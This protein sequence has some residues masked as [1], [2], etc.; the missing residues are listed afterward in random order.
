LYKIL[1]NEIYT[2][3]KISKHL[4]FEFKV[5]KGYRKGDT[6]VPSL[7]HIVLDTGIGRS[8]VDTLDIKLD[9]CSQ[10][11]AYNDDVFIMGGRLRDVEEVFASLV[12][13]KKKQER[14]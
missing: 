9:K 11:M 1:Y 2:K 7:L 4:S 5:N 14:E 6:I 13:Q 12:E 3:F 8:E 10:I